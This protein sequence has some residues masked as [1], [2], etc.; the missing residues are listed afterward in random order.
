MIHDIL[1]SHA[2]AILGTRFH[3]GNRVSHANNKTRRQFH[4]NTQPHTFFITE[5]G[6][7]YHFK[8]ISTR[9]IRTIAKKGGL[10]HF[11]LKQSAQSLSA[12]LRALK[13]AVQAHYLHSQKTNSF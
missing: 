2:C 4:T 13:E 8:A 9:A 7:S 6:R 1:M 12:D 10:G 11:L 5:L 3:T